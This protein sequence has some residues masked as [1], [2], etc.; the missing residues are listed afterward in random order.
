MSVRISPGKM[1]RLRNEIPI[2]NLITSVLNLDHKYSEDYLR[3]LCPLCRDFHTA[4][5]L[6]TNLARCFRCKKNFNPIDLVMTV[7]GYSFIQAV[8][9]LKPLLPKQE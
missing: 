2:N 9:F 6:K 5:N 7:T 1:R 3:F 4:T 8:R